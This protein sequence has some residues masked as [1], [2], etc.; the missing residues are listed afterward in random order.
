MGRQGPAA[1]PRALD[2]QD[3]ARLRRAADLQRQA[4]RLVGEPEPTIGRSKA[5]GE[6]PLMLAMSVL[7]GA[8]DGGGQR[9]RL[10]DLPA[11]RHAG[12]ARAGAD[13]G[14][15]AAGAKPRGRHDRAVADEPATLSSTRRRSAS[16]VRG[17]VGAGS[18]P[19]EAG[20]FMLVS[21][22]A[23]LGTIGGGELEYMVI[24]RAR[25]DAA[26]T[27]T[28]G[29]ALRSTC[30]SG[31]RSASAAAAGSRSSSGWSTT[32]PRRTARCGREPSEAAPAAR[33]SVR[34]RP[35]RPG[36]G[37]ALALLPLAR[38]RGRDARRGARGPAGRRRD[39]ADAD[40][41]GVVRAA[42]AGSAFVILT[43]D[44]AL[45]FLIAAEALSAATPPM[46]A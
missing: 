43:H 6:P 15:A 29:E 5:V 23:H 17:R 2:L 14:R 8:V 35:C 45:D 13:G 7:R 21:P 20:A 12:D 32:A 3:P 31:P 36:A 24:D 33:L 19:R 28:G 4:G 9:R 39:A 25:A 46:S 34:R 42:P 37:R 41:R 27:A 16:L 22:D 40:A 18:S 30:R 44:H 38:R 10:R 1:H 26:A 11:A